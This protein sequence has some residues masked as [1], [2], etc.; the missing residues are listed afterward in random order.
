DQIIRAGVHDVAVDPEL[1]RLLVRAVRAQDGEVDLV[2][3]EAAEMERPERHVAAE[4]GAV[5]A[6]PV[7]RAL[8]G[9][10]RRISAAVAATGNSTAAIA[11]IVGA[12]GQGEQLRCSVWDRCAV[13]VQH[14]MLDPRACLVPRPQRP[15]E[16]LVSQRAHPGVLIEWVRLLVVFPRAPHKQT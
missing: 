11:A 12:V 6:T 5:Q 3:P 2:V 7:D 1:E 8:T 13:L 9:G 15:G 10:E 14:T 4:P 16:R